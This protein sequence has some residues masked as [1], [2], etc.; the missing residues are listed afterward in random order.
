MRVVWCG[1]RQSL[2]NP[3]RSGQDM[4]K[5]WTMSIPV[6]AGKWRR[7]LCSGA[8]SRG[9]GRR[10]RRAPSAVLVAALRRRH[11]R[12]PGLAY[13]RYAHVFTV[14][15]D[16]MRRRIH[17]LLDNVSNTLQARSSASCSSPEGDG[18]HAW[19]SFW[20]TRPSAPQ[21]AKALSPARPK[22]RTWSARLR[23][24]SSTHALVHAAEF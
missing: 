1:Q 12:R 17:H 19:S 21:R 11:R 10:R 8:T 23:K 16:G 2:N 14:R 7:N 15:T 24:R 18:M 20:A 6:H 22:G 9:C 5:R 3:P 4:R 13:R